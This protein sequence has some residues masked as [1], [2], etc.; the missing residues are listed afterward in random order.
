MIGYEIAEYHKIH[1]VC[2][3]EGLDTQYVLYKVISEAKKKRWSLIQT[4]LAV[5][6]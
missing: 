3:K 4:I 2:C 6:R 5:L 1:S